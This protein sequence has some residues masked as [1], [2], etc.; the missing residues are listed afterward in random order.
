MFKN[1]I[2]L[3][4]VN[5]WIKN[6][7]CFIPI[8]VTGN[9][10]NI[11]LFTKTVIIFF[12]FSFSSSLVYILNDLKD[13]E[14]DKKHPV[15]CLRVIPS[16]KI[17]L[18]V[19]YILLFIL[20]VSIFLIPLI[21]FHQLLYIPLIYV[22]INIIYTY[23]TKTIPI[24]DVFSIAIG[25]VL[26]VISG[27]IYNNLPI[28]SWLILLTFTLTL[29]LALGKRGAEIK[30]DSLN[31]TRVVLKNYNLEFIKSMQDLL[32]GLVLT[33][34]MIYT[35]NN[36]TFKGNHEVL[37][38]SIFPVFFGVMR[39]K[40]LYNS[41]LNKIENPTELLYKD[42]VISLCVLCWLI[43]ILLSFLKIYGNTNI[44]LN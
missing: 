8:L 9:F 3:F 27:A 32:I 44:F 12:I 15:K 17:S 18:S 25:F 2:S 29:T 16:G 22:C 34:Y 41:K 26:R 36:K 5:H 24:F 23:Y 43:I 31:N 20:L 11:D 4:R 14:S 19:V 40:L 21:L 33:M 6:L 13:V 37:F 39:Y 10:L 7:F 35:I 38:F 42:K 1:I 28:S 30:T